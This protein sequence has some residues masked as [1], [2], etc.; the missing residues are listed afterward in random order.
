MKSPRLM[1]A[2]RRDSADHVQINHTDS[3]TPGVLLGPTE[4][5]PLRHPWGVAVWDGRRWGNSTVKSTGGPGRGQAD[6]R[7]GRGTG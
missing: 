6:V 5:P 3:G 4:G 1:K 2:M 7:G